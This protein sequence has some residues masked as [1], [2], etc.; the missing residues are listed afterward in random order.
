MDVRLGECRRDG[1]S[2]RSGLQ[3]LTERPGLEEHG[4]LAS[5]DRRDGN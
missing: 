3:E 5:M 2:I 4:E 1:E